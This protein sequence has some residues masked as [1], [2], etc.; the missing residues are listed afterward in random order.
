[1]AFSVN[2]ITHGS[3]LLVLIIVIRECKRK[4]FDFYTPL[5]G[6]LPLRSP[7]PLLQRLASPPTVHIPTSNSGIDNATLLRFE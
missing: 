3:A 1:M 5:A 2:H 7:D 4:L 6:P